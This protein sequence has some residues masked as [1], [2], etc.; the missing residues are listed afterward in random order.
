MAILQV[1]KSQ[2]W[3]IVALAG[4]T[5]PVVG[6]VCLLLASP[7]GAPIMIL[8]APAVDP[9]ADL[10]RRSFWLVSAVALVVGM[11]VAIALSQ[12]IIWRNGGKRRRTWTQTTV[13]TAVLAFCLT[14]TFSLLD[15]HFG[16]RVSWLSIDLVNANIDM[17]AFFHGLNALGAVPTV[18]LVAAVAS[19]VRPLGANKPPIDVRRLRSLIR[20][21]RQLLLV[22]AIV[23]TIATV[24]LFAAQNWAVAWV[25]NLSKPI[26]EALSFSLALAMG[27]LYTVFVAV[28]FIPAM[29]MHRRAANDLA[30]SKVGIGA[31]QSELKEWM[32]ARALVFSPWSEIG[33][34][35]LIL[36]PLI[37]GTL[38]PIATAMF[39]Y[40]VR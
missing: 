32:S 2:P 29:L 39:D 40:L 15:Q 31:T 23:L 36:G 21:L 11:I 5:T 30:G 37:T 13:V 38:I 4:L 1:Q 17:R 16:L 33:R 28:L 6:L 8:P 27:G 14:L 9:A 25:H 24:E 3:V 18:F 12:T 35:L 34:G 10:P 26:V 22:I 19:T 7:Q 20:D